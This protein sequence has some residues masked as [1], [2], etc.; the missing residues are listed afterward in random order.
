MEINLERGAVNAAYDI[1]ENGFE[2]YFNTGVRFGF[3]D[4]NDNKNDILEGITTILRDSGRNDI[5]TQLLEK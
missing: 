2:F 5:A 4:E 3:F 1:I